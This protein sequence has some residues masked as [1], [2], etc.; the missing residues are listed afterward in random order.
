M[1][2]GAAAAAAATVAGS[3]MSSQASKDAANTSADAQRYAADQAAQAAKFNPVGITTRFGTSNF[4][5]SN[6][7]T[8]DFNTWAASQGYNPYGAPATAAGETTLG[9]EGTPAMTP[10]QLSALQARYNAEVPRTQGDITGAGYTLAP[11]LKAIQ[12]RLMSSAG[13]YNYNVDTSQLSNAANQAFGGG[14]TLFNLGNQYTNISPEQ[15]QQQ[16]IQNT[17][18]SLAASRERDRAAVANQVF[19]TGRTGLATGGTASGMLQSNPEYAALYNARAQ[20]DLD[21]TQR[22]QEQGRLNQQFG[23]GLFGL[24]ANLNTSGASMLSSIPAL[25]T[26]Y[27]SPLQ[28]YLAT[29]GSIEGMGQDAFKLSSE[30]AGRQSTAGA[31]AGQFLYSGGSAAARAQQAANQYSVPGA[32][33]TAAGTSPTAS[34]WFDKLITSGSSPTYKGPSYGTNSDFNNSWYDTNSYD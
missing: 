13:N 21:I 22:A 8:Q 2:W 24:G 14:S 17:Q 30:L 25:Q 5:R 32:L 6:T 16:Y 19:R 15:A 33:L 31:N 9:S 18:A 20:Q 27:L 34:A 1:P 12:D 7:P 4:T 29:S 11:D 28:Q 23:A 10:E 3:Y 26:A